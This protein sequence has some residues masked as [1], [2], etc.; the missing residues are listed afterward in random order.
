[1]E[2]S[3]PAC[4][5]S[6][7]FDQ[8]PSRSPQRRQGNSR[9]RALASFRN[10]RIKKIYGAPCPYKR[11][12]VAIDYSKPIH[13]NISTDRE[14]CAPL[15]TK[16]SHR[17]RQL[18]AREDIIL[19]GLRPVSA[20]RL[21]FNHTEEG[22]DYDEEEESL[23]E[24]GGAQQ[25]RPASSSGACSLKAQQSPRR[26]RLLT[27]RPKSDRGASVLLETSDKDASFYR[28]DSHGEDSRQKEQRA[29]LAIR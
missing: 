23:L 8:D 14:Y 15:D 17:Q 11:P 1:M 29:V 5:S 24:A 10:D 7:R 2:R 4:A 27:N 28:C 22:G 20:S 16:I 26:L 25:R 19:G 12:P 3:T 6:N 18:C 13:P 21:N 9:Q